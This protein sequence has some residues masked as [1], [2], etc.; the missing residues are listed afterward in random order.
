MSNVLKNIVR[1][2]R[3]SSIDPERATV[4]VAFEDKSG[5]VSYDLPVLVQQTLK[6]KDYCMPDPG[7]HVVCLFLP[8]GIA[9]GFCLGAFY[10]ATDTPPVSNAKKRHVSFEDGT[11]I[12]YD[13]ETSTLTIN[14]VGAVN[15]TGATGD[16]IVNG[17]S[18]VNHIHPES[19]GSA[20]G[21]P[22]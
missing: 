7:E 1:V 9:Q 19:I 5:L 14:T 6:N 18:L 11:T 12:E 15:I 8:N 13:R 3:V 17:I 10:S 16:V 2:G 20:T 21:K 4:R 22:Q